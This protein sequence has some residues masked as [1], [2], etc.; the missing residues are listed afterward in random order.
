MD[1]MQ[2][3]AVLGGRNRIILEQ[4]LLFPAVD[5][6][7][8]ISR[9]VAIAVARQAQADGVAKRPFSDV[10]DQIDEAMWSPIYRDYVDGP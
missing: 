2:H 9:N 8:E 3:D 7:R 10:E 6:L 4:G 5:R 1:L